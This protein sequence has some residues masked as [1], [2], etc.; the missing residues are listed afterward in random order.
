MPRRLKQVVYGFFYLIF[1]AVLGTGIYFLFLKPEVSCFDKKQN[2]S[3]EG[4]DC[5]RVCGNICLPATFRNLAVAG[6]PMVF[7]I[8]DSRATVLVTVENPNLDF[9]ARSFEYGLF[10]GQATGTQPIV[11]GKSFIHAGEIK[12]FAFPNLLIPEGARRSLEFRIENPFW[13]RGEDFARPK[14]AVQDQRASVSGG[15]L[16]VEGRI[17][18]KDTV[19]FGKV[20]IVGVFQGSFGRPV[21]ASVTEIENVSLNETRVFTLIHPATQAVSAAVPK[22]FLYAIRP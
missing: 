7:S 12:Y 9:G 11:S 1:F 2:Q 17:V 16:A 8:D 15:T 13:V 10:A 22:I 14:L 18:N 21:G 3:E 19:R 5:G 4:V 6:S 20:Y